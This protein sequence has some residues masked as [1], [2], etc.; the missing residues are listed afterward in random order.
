VSYAVA[1]AGGA[2]SAERFDLETG[3]GASIAYFAV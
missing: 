2:F 1:F 3:G